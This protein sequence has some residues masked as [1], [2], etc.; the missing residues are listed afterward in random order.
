MIRELSIANLGVIEHTRLEF[1]P[2]FTVLT[3]ET[4]AGK[5]LITTALGQLL[6]AK[7]DAGLVRHGSD[8]AVI[9]CVLTVPRERA[10]I[11]HLQEIGALIDD[12][13]IVVTRTIGAA[14]RSRAIVGSRSVAASLLADIVGTAVT[15]H[16]QHGQTRLTKPAEQRALLDASMSKAAALLDAHWNAWNVL[17]LAR[18]S[19]ADAT[20]AQ[21]T[22]A[23]QIE[24]MRQLVADVESVVPMP[25]EDVEIIDRIET[26]AK[27]DEILRICRMAHGALAGDGESDD[28][29]VLQLL[30]QV[31]KQLEHVDIPG[32]FANWSERV[33]EL[34]ETAAAL[35]HEIDQFATGLDADPATLDLL[36]S[37]KAAITALLRRW[38]TSLPDLLQQYDDASRQLAFTDDPATQ[39]AALQAAVIEAEAAQDRTA[40]ALHDARVQAAKSLAKTVESELRELGLPHASFGIAVTRAGEPTQFGDDLVEFTF[41]A[42][43][44]LPPQALAAIGSGGE[45]SRVMLALEVAAVDDRRRTFIFD[46]VDAGIGGKAALEVGKRLAQLAAT[47]QVIVVTHLPQVA[48]FADQ[49]IVVEKTVGGR[50]TVTATRRLGSGE[51][52]R[53]VARM[54]SGVEDSSAA[55]AHAAEL[56]AMA[57][58]V[59]RVAG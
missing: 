54:L 59:R 14:T 2:G 42:N 41:S 52:A 57:A 26:L 16:G 33:V 19:L 48:A 9:D 21:S 55:A 44:G 12:D 49:H 24:R 36:Q 58:D 27:S 53:E 38:N 13:E 40:A 34:R 31:R 51:R 50:S 20:T 37:R 18:Q 25:N 47:Q 10:A 1:A 30:S 23:A 45:L 29:D 56:L 11:E 35:A 32:P 5:T 3:G 8:E 4:G 43:P 28:V 46:E 6:G 17:R 22:A 39:I 7:A 15:L